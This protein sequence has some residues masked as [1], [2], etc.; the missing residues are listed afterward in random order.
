MYL[1]LSTCAESGLYNSSKYVQRSRIGCIDPKYDQLQFS[2]PVD[3]HGHQRMYVIS[4]S[5]PSNYI[6]PLDQCKYFL[7][8]EDASVS[9][10]Q[11]LATRVESTKRAIIL[12]KYIKNGTVNK[13]IQ[14]S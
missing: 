10:S 11:K 5:I 7:M 12:L 8:P 4:I 1:R 3:V 6:S 14:R 2:S 9:L 13:S